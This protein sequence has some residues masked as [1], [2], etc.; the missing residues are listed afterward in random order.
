MTTMTTISNCTFSQQ[1]Q[2]LYLHGQQGAAY[3]RTIKNIEYEWIEDK[4]KLSKV[5]RSLTQ[6]EIS[7]PVN[8]KFQIL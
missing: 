4:K 6:K 8:H 3:I 7:L 1:G 5:N 2:A